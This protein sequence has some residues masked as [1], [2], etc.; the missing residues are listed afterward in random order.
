MATEQSERRQL[1][2]SPEEYEI[3][4]AEAVQ[5]DGVTIEVEREGEGIAPMLIIAIVGGA[6]LV[7]G[8]ADYI[9]QR[10]LGGYVIDLRDGAE[11]REYR[12]KAVEYGLVYVYGADGKVRVLVKKGKTFYAEVIDAVLNTL[13]G[14]VTDSAK[15]A[16]DAIKKATGSDTEVTTDDDPDAD[17]PPEN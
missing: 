17:L 14:I 3:L 1:E 6:A 5:T 16:A 13:K 8:M 7:A 10:R 15:A 11:K 9:I 12:S 2:V 4:H